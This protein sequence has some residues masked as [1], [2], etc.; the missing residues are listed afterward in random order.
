LPVRLGLGVSVLV[1]VLVSYLLQ[2]RRVAQRA[3]D[4]SAERQRADEKFQLLFNLVP[5]GV[6]LVR[7]ADGRI[8]E[9]NQAYAHLVG[10][11]R[12]ELSGRT[13]Q[14]MNLW[15]SQEERTAGLERLEGEGHLHEVRFGIRR[16]DGTRREG[17]Y[18][19]SRV[20]LEGETCYLS[21]IR[22]V[23]ER[24]QMEQRLAESQ[25]LEAIGRLAGGIAHDFNNIITGISGYA[26]LAQQGL[27]D[28]DPRLADL[29]E[30]TRASRRASDLTRQLLTFARRQLTTP[31]LVDLGD[32]V[33]Q[34]QGLLRHLAGETVRI[35]LA[36][37]TTPVHAMIDPAQFEQVLTNLTLNACHAMP[38]GGAVQ[39]AV[40]RVGGTAVVS[41]TDRGSGIAPEVLP[42][43]FEP[44]FTTKPPGSGTGLG[45][46]MVRGIVDEAGG[47]IE[48]DS[49]LGAGSTFRVLLPAVDHVP[50][51]VP[52]EAPTPTV[53]T[54]RGLILMVEDEPQVR[55]L[56]SR[57][58]TQLGYEVLAA[59]DGT[60]ALAL[61][62]AHHG[63][64]ALLLTDMVM[65]RM[66]GGELVRRMREL[67]PELPVLL[68]SGYSEELVAA[69]HPDHPF[70]AKP[71]TPAELAEAVGRVLSA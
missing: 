24:I 3:S 52:A 30:I 53:P 70:L 21:V 56:T 40:T 46:S 33:R 68:M 55:A 23:H 9:A 27:P 42:H 6:L 22:D 1:A 13:V 48:V 15:A 31:Q 71:F 2:S 26:T 34:A 54:G 44:F 51:E 69:E 38:H 43:I 16:P 62:A 66:G 4:L 17:I 60:E 10:R 64:I 11:S 28:G 39:I 47:E 61:A 32:L 65:P 35:E 45:L 63:P 18:S 20:V 19:A 67:L 8:L 49:R 25:R 50:G 29:A 37:P 7:A 58:L 5:D 12:D 36:L 41:V 59:E 57:V 14:E